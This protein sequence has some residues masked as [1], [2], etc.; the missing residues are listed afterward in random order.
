[1]Q[2]WSSLK[3]F[4]RVYLFQI[5][6]ESLPIP[7]AYHLGDKLLPIQIALHSV[8]LPL[9]IV[10]R[11]RRYSNFKQEMNELRYF[12]DPLIANKNSLKIDSKNTH[13]FLRPKSFDPKNTERANCCCCYYLDYQTIKFADFYQ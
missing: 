13:I 12:S 5:A 7:E 6:L 1:M 10:H 8:Q 11:T 4:T 2:S 3:K 9:F